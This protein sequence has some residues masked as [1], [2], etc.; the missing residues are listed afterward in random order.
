CHCYIQLHNIPSPRHR[1][2]QMECHCRLPERTTRT[3]RPSVPL[4]TENQS[5][6]GHSSQQP[7]TGT[8]SYTPPPLGSCLCCCRD[9]QS[10]ATERQSSYSAV[11]SEWESGWEVESNSVNK[12]HYL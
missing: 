8:A 6:A 10:F 4:T 3:C 11:A 9:L 5:R 2:P 12:H 1:S 7:N